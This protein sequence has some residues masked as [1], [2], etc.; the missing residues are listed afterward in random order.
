M[1]VLLRRPVVGETLAQIIRLIEESARVKAPIQT[2][3]DKISRGLFNYNYSSY[4]N[5]FDLVF[6]LNASLV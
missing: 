3:A 1:A 2:F 6:F 5:I 4:F